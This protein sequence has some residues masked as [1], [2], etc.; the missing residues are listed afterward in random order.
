ML[1]LILDTFILMVLIRLITGDENE[2]W[3]KPALIAVLAAVAMIG[4][5]LGANGTP[6]YALL[7]LLGAIGGVGV[8]VALACWAL[9][10]VEF[11]KSLL[12]GF[13]FVVYKIA[14]SILFALALGGLAG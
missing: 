14:I 9:L 4:A 2:G 12:I 3:G 7:I 8:M 6:E 1:G 13:C 5:N 10:S 11:P